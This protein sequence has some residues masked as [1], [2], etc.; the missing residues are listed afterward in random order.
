MKKSLLSLAGLLFSLNLHAADC[1]DATVDTQLCETKEV[2]YVTGEALTV[3]QKATE[4]GSPVEIYE[5]LRNNAEYAL[6]H[7]SRS[8]SLNSVLSLRGNDVDLASSLIAMLRSQGIK[9]RY[10]VGDIKLKKS[11]LANWLGVI[12]NDLAVSI[13]RDQG[14]QNINDTDPVDVVFQHV[15][16]EALVD[17]DNYRAGNNSS[18]SIACVTAGGSCKW[19]S[20]DASYKQKKYK[21]TYRMLLRDLNFDYDAYYNAENPTSANFKAGLKNKNPLEIFEEQALVFLRANHPGVTLEDVLD[22]GEVIKDESGVLPA[23]LPYDVVGAVTRYDSIA[24]YDAANTVDWTKYLT[25]T[26]QL[27]GCTAIGLPTYRVSLAE[28]S[29]KKLTL[30]MF[31][32]GTTKI[33]AHRLDGVQVGSSISA[34]G[35]ITFICGGVSTV[36]QIGTPMD[37]EL[38][39]DIAPADAPVKVNY[40][41]LTFGGYYLIASGG[42][43]SNWTQVKRAYEKLLAAN[44]EFQ[45]VVDNAGATRTWMKMVM[46]WRIR[47]IHYY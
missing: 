44:D 17:Y 45:I 24:D 9:A 12:N 40:S 39:V 6:Y 3:G 22:S 1:L 26:M 32:N 43:T 7:G 15:W 27:P 42:E 30:T 35:T 33:F 47:E 25:S 41:N 14:V 29:T 13:M 5:Y 20:L 28:L 31:Q 21:N 23:S 18:S 2:L 34:G 8:N 16:V 11:Q 37:V 19:V 4:L 36:I 46:V 10:T 38:T